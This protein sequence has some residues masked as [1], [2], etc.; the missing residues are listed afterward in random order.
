MTLL[1]GFNSN[2]QQQSGETHSQTQ[3][4]GI[5]AVNKNVLPSH[6]RRMEQYFNSRKSTHD[7]PTPG[8]KSSFLY[9]Y[10]FP[11]LVLI[12]WVPVRAHSNHS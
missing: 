11:F 9:I 1:M 7:K 4:L 3:A 8:L 5:H 6:L 12:S 2:L 10:K